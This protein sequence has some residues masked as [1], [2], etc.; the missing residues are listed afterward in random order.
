[1][2]FVIPLLPRSLLRMPPA[3]PLR[4][5]G[6]TPL[7]RYYGPVRQAPAFAALRLLGS[8]GYLAS[9]GFLRGAGSPSLFPPMAVWACRHPPP[10]RMDC[11]QGRLR[12]SPAAFAASESARHP[13]LTSHEA[14][15][16]CSLVVA[17]RSLAHPAFRGFVD[18]LHRRGLPCRC[19]PSYAASTFYRF[20][21]FTLWIHG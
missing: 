2:G 17:A 9:A 7:P 18:G 12:G 19:H 15:T 8:R 21:T 5:T 4:S 14:S 16:G 20:G 13:E 3:G 10:R 11:P 6:I 1:V